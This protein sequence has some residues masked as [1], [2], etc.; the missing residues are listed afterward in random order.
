MDLGLPTGHETVNA[1]ITYIGLFF[2]HGFSGLVGT[3]LG[4]RCARGMCVA[5]VV[6]SFAAGVQRSYGSNARIDVLH[7]SQLPLK[8]ALPGKRLLP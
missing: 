1:V 8:Y 7:L 4:K 5:I 3:N 6:A 2:M